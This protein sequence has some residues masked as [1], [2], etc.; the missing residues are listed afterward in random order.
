MTLT[1]WHR[2]S[3]GPYTRRGRIARAVLFSEP[4][5]V[6]PDSETGLNESRSFDEEELRQGVTSLSLR[7]GGNT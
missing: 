6:V 7:Q 4:P 1:Q 2:D 5:K 3:H